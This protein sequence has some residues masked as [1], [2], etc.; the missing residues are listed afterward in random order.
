MEYYC[1][2]SWV[3]DGPRFYVYHMIYD[4]KISVEYTLYVGY[5]FEL[6]IMKGNLASVSESIFIFGYNVWSIGGFYRAVGRFGRPVQ[7]PERIVKPPALFCPIQCPIIS[8]C[9][10]RK[11]RAKRNPAYQAGLFCEYIGGYC[12]ALV[13]GYR[14]RC[15]WWRVY[16]AIYNPAHIAHNIRYAA[17]IAARISR[18]LCRC[19]VR[20][21]GD[22]CH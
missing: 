21:V 1:R 17:R 20:A 22:N 19:L 4:S 2:Q 12:P 13:C 6:V 5:S 18:I 7:H 3:L 16:A 15:R 9:I 8:R 14:L 10:V 11:V